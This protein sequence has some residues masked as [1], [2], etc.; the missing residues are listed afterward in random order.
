[1]RSYTVQSDFPFGSNMYIVEDSN[2]YI[3][4]DPSASVKKAV[5]ETGIVPQNVKYIVLTHAHFDHILAIDEWKAATSGEV[6]V[7]ERDANALTDA[8]V[9]C[10]KLFLN[11]ARGYFGDYSTLKN[12]DRLTIGTTELSVYETPGHT[13]GSVA[14]FC[15]NRLFVGDTV[16]FGGAVG[17]TD[18]P[19]GDQKML[20]GS[21][22]RILEFDDECEVYPGHGK[23]TTILELKKY[24]GNTL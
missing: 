16:F 19:T 18:L 8:N 24:I 3:V 2:E 15:R 9:N 11:E 23:A 20:I 17:R 5:L 4:I 22:K 10:Y 14:L 12:G 13:I 21:L 1:M 6:Y 7:S